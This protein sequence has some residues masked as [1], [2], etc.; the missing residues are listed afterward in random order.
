MV[1]RVPKEQLTGHRGQNDD[2][3]RVI[4]VS[5]DTVGSKNLYSSIVRTAPGG[6][7]EIHHHGE[8]ETSIYI[9]RGRA[10]FYSGE[11]LRDIVDA[12]EGDFIFVP[13]YEVHVEENASDSDDLVVLLSRNCPGSVIHYV[14]GAIPSA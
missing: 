11:S 14:K 13:A 6:R 4:A 7:T 1:T 9:L 8:C 3:E 12:T 10:R 2:M 5:R